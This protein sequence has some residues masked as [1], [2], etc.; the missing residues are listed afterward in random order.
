MKNTGMVPIGDTGFL[1]LQKITE[2]ELISIYE[3][4][5]IANVNNLEN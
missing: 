2:S 5:G 4:D 1:Q 3:I